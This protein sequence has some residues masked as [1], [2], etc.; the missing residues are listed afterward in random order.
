MLLCSPLNWPKGK[1]NT[2]YY[3][4][5]SLCQHVSVCLS[6]SLSLIF[7]LC[8]VFHF[9]LAPPIF[10]FLSVR[11]VFFLRFP[12]N[13]KYIKFSVL[14]NLQK[15][16]SLSLF[17]SLHLSLII[18]TSLSHLCFPLL[19]LPPLPLTP[20]SLSLPLR[21]AHYSI[22]IIDLVSVLNLFHQN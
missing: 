13:S 11:F 9:F 16:F 3:Y 21:C 7:S 2:K 17:P 5:T 15:I 19:F 14:C 10:L 22:V 18:T 12:F 6:L 8:Q 4:V 1:N 20:L